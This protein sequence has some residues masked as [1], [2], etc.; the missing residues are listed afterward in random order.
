MY[1]YTYTSIR[2][3][4]RLRL[5]LRLHLRLSTYVIFKALLQHAKMLQHQQPVEGQYFKQSV[6]SRHPSPQFVWLVGLGAQL[7]MPLQQLQCLP[8]LR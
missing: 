2:L 5:R 1:I 6:Y 8:R 4:L 3:L 7:L